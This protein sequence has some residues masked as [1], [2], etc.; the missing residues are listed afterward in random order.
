ML[1]GVNRHC[2]LS[3]PSGELTCTNSTMT[4]CPVSNYL[5]RVPCSALVGVTT[6]WSGAKYM[7]DALQASKA[8]QAQQAQEGGKKKSK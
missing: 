7:R 6:V 4:V 8:W 1:H 5:P 2:L 3:M